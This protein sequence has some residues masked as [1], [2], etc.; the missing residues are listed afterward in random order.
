MNKIIYIKGAVAF[1][2]P[3]YTTLGASLAPYAIDGAKPPTTVAVI[4]IGAAVMVSSLSALGS[5]LST[6]FADHKAEVQ[7]QQPD[8]PAQTK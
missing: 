8:N 1:L 2:I 7:S 4:I 6:S 5:F 3:F